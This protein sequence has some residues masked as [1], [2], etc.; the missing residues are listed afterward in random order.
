MN[1]DPCRP[2]ELVVLGMLAHPVDK[3]IILAKNIVRKMIQEMFFVLKK[4]VFML[5]I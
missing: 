2:W 3:I 5:L 4:F 1:F